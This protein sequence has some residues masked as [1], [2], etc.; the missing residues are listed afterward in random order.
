MQKASEAAFGKHEFIMGLA[1]GFIMSGV[2]SV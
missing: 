1:T 2:V